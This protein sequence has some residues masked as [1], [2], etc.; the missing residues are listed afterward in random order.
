MNPTL[1]ARLRDWR[2]DPY[3]RVHPPAPWCVPLEPATA[4]LHLGWS[5]APMEPPTAAP[6]PAVGPSE[7]RPPAPGPDLDSA[8]VQAS[9]EGGGDMGCAVVAGGT[10]AR[11]SL[12]EGD[13]LERQAEPLRPLRQAPGAL[14]VALQAAGLLAAELRSDEG[15]AV[16][17]T[18]LERGADERTATAL[19][20]APWAADGP[21]AVGRSLEGPAVVIS[22]PRTATVVRLALVQAAGESPRSPAEGQPRS[23]PARPARPAR[24]AP[25]LQPLIALL[26]LVLISL[27]EGWAALRL[28]V[29]QIRAI[30]WAPAPEDPAGQRPLRPVVAAGP[31]VGLA[32]ETG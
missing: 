32:G 27:L 17:P 20:A 18:T 15:T 5:P 24:P 31:V 2:Q 12:P 14:A 22:A 3:W 8:P 28:L 26:L 7:E 19:I 21:P 6:Q 25:P 23:A 13:G 30:W 29:G 16:E 1:S 10:V 11:L 4:L 9:S